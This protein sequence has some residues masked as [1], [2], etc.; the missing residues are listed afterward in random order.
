MYFAMI[1]NAAEQGRE[2]GVAFDWDIPLLEGYEWTLLKN[3]AKHPSLTEFRG[4]DTPQLYREIREGG[5][6]AVI[7]NG[8]VTKTCLQALLAS[9]LAGIP[10]IVRGEVNGMR[11][12]ASWKCWL[13]ARLLA[14]YAACLSIGT[15]NRRYLLDAGVP[16]ARIFATPYCVENERFSTAADVARIQPGRDALQARFGLDPERTTFVF[17]GKFVDKKRPGDIVE[18]IRRLD[19]NERARMQL[20]LVGGGPMEQ[21]LR[22]SAAGLPVHFAGFLNQSEI[23][24][25]YAAA[26]CLV[27]P[28]DHG[29]TWGLVVNEAMACGLPA[30]VSDQ[31]GCAVDLVQA[32][33]TGDVFPYGDVAALS[34]LLARHGLVRNGLAKMGAAARVQVEAGYNF[35]NV[36][37]GVLAALTTVTGKTV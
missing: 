37:Q 10:C 12:R 28:S 14:R 2:F 11:P 23:T 7:V 24:A 31:V 25:A 6:E 32:G 17:S 29:E 35:E 20:L 1:P 30:I 13:H 36:R 5:F 26:D 8:W 16:A 19:P 15:N 4:C 3:R 18:A 27:L 9:R 21:E 34:A 33:Y 22:T